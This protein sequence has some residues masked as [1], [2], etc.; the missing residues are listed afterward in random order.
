VQLQGGPK[1]VPEKKG[2]GH[3][4]IIARKLGTE[5]GSAKTRIMT[6]PVKLNEGGGVQPLGGRRGTGG[7]ERYDLLLKKQGE[8]QPVQKPLPTAGNFRLGRTLGK[9]KQ[10]E[11]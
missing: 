10:S 4:C 1:N 6:Q 11:P 2:M 5:P 3:L 9:Q 7:G 8:P